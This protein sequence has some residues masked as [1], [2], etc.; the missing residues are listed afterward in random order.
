VQKRTYHWMVKDDLPIT[1]I[2]PATM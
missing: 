2:E 1:S